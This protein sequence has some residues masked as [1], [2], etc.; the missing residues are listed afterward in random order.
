M[1][2]RYS[3]NRGNSPSRRTVSD[4]SARQTDPEE[5]LSISRQNMGGRCKPVIRA[6]QVES[7]LVLP[8]VHHHVETARHGDEELMALL[9]GVTG[10]VRPAGHIVEIEHPLDRKRDVPIVLQKGQIAARILDL[11][12]LNN[13]AFAQF[14][15]T[16]IRSQFLL[17]LPLQHLPFRQPGQRQEPLTNLRPIV[18]F[19]HKMHQIH[20]F[21]ANHLGGWFNAGLPESELPVQREDRSGWWTTVLTRSW[22]SPS[23]SKA[24][25]KA[26]I[27]LGIAAGTSGADDPPARL[28]ARTFQIVDAVCPDRD[29]AG[30]SMMK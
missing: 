16:L 23:L 2:R 17:L 11:R 30:V 14:H 28:C 8:V 18:C 6:V 4:A 3:G 9:E 19:Q 12:Q 1:A 10:A 21:A 27:A 20:R 29:P 13:L 5:K 26:R 22:L 25:S 24:M 7:L 15:K